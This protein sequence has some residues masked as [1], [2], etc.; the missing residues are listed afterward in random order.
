MAMLALAAPGA[1]AHAQDS[2]LLRFYGG[3]RVGYTF[4]TQSSPVSTMDSSR[5]EQVTGLSLGVNFNRYFGVELA[6]DSFE[7]DVEL[8]GGSRIGEYGIFTLIPQARLRY[9][10]Y[11]DRLVPY[12]LAGVGLS[13]NEFNDRKQEGIG[14]SI[15]ASD[16]TV[17]G[18]VGAGIEYF[19]TSNIAVGVEARYLVSRDQRIAIDGRSEKANLDALLTSVNMRL[20][21][22]EMPGASAAAA[23]PDYRTTGRFY[24]A[25][26]LGGGA[27]IDEDIASGVEAAPVNSAIGGVLSLSYG[28]ALGMDLTRVFGAE[29]AVE[30][31]DFE[32]RIPG[33]GSVGEYAI[34]T[35]IP[36]LRFRYPVFEGRLTPYLV[37]GVGVSFGEFKDRKPRGRDFDIGGE[38]FALAA[39]AGIGVEYFVASNIAVGLETKYLY[40]RDHTMQVS[41]RDRDL[42]L[43]SMLT[44]LG[45][46]IYFGRRTVQD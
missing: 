29:F 9:P 7:T 3:L 40:S 12:V 22:P 41:G 37:T 4:L 33:L 18:A 35:Y 17:V 43:D 1:V 6:A 25:L 23:P 20:L 45:L 5:F 8:H 14:H 32:V 24:A 26:R 27:V 21:F 42:R 11:G 31:Y 34:Y 2:D 28:G 15:H 44:S 13:R 38:D 30:G 46:R 10:L 19:V 16:T 36:Q 39:V